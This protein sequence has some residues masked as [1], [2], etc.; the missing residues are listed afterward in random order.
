VD[1]YNWTYDIGFVKDL[2]WD[3][4]ILEEKQIDTIAAK[5][6]QNLPFRTSFMTARG[7]TYLEDS[8]KNYVAA[9]TGIIGVYDYYIGG[10]SKLPAGVKNALQEYKSY[11]TEVEK[12]KD[13]IDK[14]ESYI[15]HIEELGD[16]TI[17]FAKFFNPGQLALDNFIETEGSGNT[18]SP[19]FYSSDSTPPRKISSFNN[20]G[21]ANIG[22]K[23]KTTPIADI[24]GPDFANGLLQGSGLVDKDGYLFLDPTSG[25]IA[26]A[27]Y[28]WDAESSKRV[29]DIL[30]EMGPVTTVA[31]LP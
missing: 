27:V 2:P 18:K 29:K 24:L 14:E 16:L 17:N 13:A 11:R 7:G 3:E 8:R 19:V 21:D 23:I 6:N 20:L 22:F 5:L 28:H 30:S 25:M 4:S 9:L 10:A 15:G 1:S 12:A 26:W 31:K